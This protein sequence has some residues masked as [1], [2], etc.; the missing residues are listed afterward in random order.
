MLIEERREQIINLLKNHDGPIT[1][2]ELS[3]IF[4]VSRQVI[5]QDIAVM[6]AQGHTIL[7]TSNGYM[8]PQVQL[9][10]DTIKK[11]VCKHESYEQIEEELKIIVDMGITV[12]DVIVKH[13][14]YGEIKRP[15]MIS[16]RIDLVDF[17][18]KVKQGNAEPLSVLTDGEHIHTLRVSNQRAYEKM[19]EL[20]SQKGYLIRKE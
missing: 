1:G 16:S 3:K 5:V 7:A 12:L 15:L 19:V 9:K 18:K 14:V 2:T 6:R 20:L 8:M 4:Q 11:I 10:Q 13:P 17:M